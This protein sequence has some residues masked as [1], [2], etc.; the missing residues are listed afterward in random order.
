MKAAEARKLIGQEVSVRKHHSGII[1]TGIILSV[2]GRNV[3]VDFYGMTD[4]LWLP[5]CTI[6]PIVAEL[7]GGAN[8]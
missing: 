4:W 5:D 8:D 6:K 3:K 1:A 2:E 7:E